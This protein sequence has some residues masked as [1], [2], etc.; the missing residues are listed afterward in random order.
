[1]GCLPKA[2]SL[3][4]LARLK[5]FNDAL[6]GIELEKQKRASRGKYQTHL[7]LTHFLCKGT[8]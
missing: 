1:M 4:P 6:I 8:L 7:S 5:D 3:M 2:L